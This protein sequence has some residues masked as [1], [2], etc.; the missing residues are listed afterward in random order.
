M[1]PETLYTLLNLFEKSPYTSW[2]GILTNGTLI[3]DDSI[4][5][6]LRIKKLREV[7]ISLDGATANTHNSNRGDGVFALALKALDNLKTAGITT[8]VMCT[9]TKG[10]IGEALDM[11]DLALDHGVSAITFERCLPLGEG[12]KHD[13]SPTAQEVR[14]IFMQLARKKKVLDENGQLKIRTSRPLWGLTNSDFGGYCP[15]GISSL[16]ILHN[17]DILPCRRLE[18]PIGNVL[19]EGIYKAWYTSP[20]LW[21]MRKKSKSAFGCGSCSLLSKCSGCR[22]AAYAWS[23]DYLG[24]DPHCWKK[25]GEIND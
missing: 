1:H 21:K 20:V 12:S 2:M 19:S 8:A 14:D 6:L 7:Q 16:C 13:V 3:S 18:I 5:Q 10:N 23:G 22:A 24:K 9:L 4:Q 25:E 15:V 11:V 17:G